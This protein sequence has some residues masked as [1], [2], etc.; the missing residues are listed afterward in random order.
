MLSVLIIILVSFWGKPCSGSGL[1]PHSGLLSVTQVMENYDEMYEFL[2]SGKYPE[3]FT[4]NQKRVLRR[5]SKDNFKVCGI[6]FNLELARLLQFLLNHTLRL[7]MDFYITPRMEINGNKFQ[8]V[9]KKRR[10]Y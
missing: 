9:M 2:Y 10:E 8:G 1:F 7:R 6:F 4:K 3:N 5:K